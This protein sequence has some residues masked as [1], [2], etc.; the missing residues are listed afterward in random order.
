M[1]ASSS[2]ASR[3]RAAL[4]AAFPHTLPV[5]MGFTCLGLAYGVLMS[6][7]GYGPIWSLAMSA[8]AFCGSMQYVALTLLTVAFDPLQAFLMSLMVN[9][10]H[11]FYGLSMLPKYSGLGRSRGVLVFMLCDETFSIV[12]AA[13]PPKDVPAKDFYLAV[14]VLDYLYW[15]VA[16][17]LGG[18]LGGLMTFDLTG[19]DFVLTAL[20]FV[21]FLDKWEQKQNRASAL[22]GVGAAIACLLLLGPQNFIIPAMVLILAALLMGRDRLCAR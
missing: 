20:I 16:S 13:Q 1:Q 12:C 4:R 6:A 17:F 9:A 11:L 21:L 18:L 22:I 3:V 15:V 10:R 7:K 8:I 14:S 2:S 5:L 19:L